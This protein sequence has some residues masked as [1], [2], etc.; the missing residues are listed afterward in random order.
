MLLRV[1]IICQYRCEQI[2]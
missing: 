1:S 2:W